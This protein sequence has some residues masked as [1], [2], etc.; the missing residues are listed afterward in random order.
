MAI[1]SNNGFGINQKNINKTASRALGANYVNENP[2]AITVVMSGYSAG[3]AATASALVGT[4][5]LYGS[6]T[7]VAGGPVSIVFNVEPKQT[8]KI[9]SANVTLFSWVEFSK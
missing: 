4:E 1:T 7:N 2:F 8:Y 5:T 6:G 9:N 3:T